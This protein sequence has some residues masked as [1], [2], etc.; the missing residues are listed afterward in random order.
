MIK[1]PSP[2]M[3]FGLPSEIVCPIDMND[4]ALSI[5][6]CDPFTPDETIE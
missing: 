6:D 1:A 4:D 2:E 3:L 5:S